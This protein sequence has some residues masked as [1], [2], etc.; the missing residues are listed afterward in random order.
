MDKY[1]IL[2][3]GTPGKGKTTAAQNMDRATTGYLNVECKPLPF[4]GAF[5]HHIKPLTLADAKA[6]LK[7]LV[8]NPAVEAIFFDSFSAYV[9]LVLWEAR[10]TKKGFDV[11]N[12]YS[13]EIGN[14][15]KY[16]K[17]CGKD[18]IVTAHYEV[19]GLEGSQEKRVKVKGNE[20]S[21]LIEKEFTIVL[22]A[23]NRLNE[24]GRP[25]YFFNIFQE[26]TSAKCP[27]DIFGADVYRVPNDYKL[28]MDKL[29]E[30][31]NA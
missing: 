17:T 5:T 19:L 3:V 31:R 8:D 13:E 10:K 12:Y 21:G 29:N 26:G 6:G 4:K 14:I 18:V 9:D 2:I 27:P 7:S 1:Q 15:L 16:I 11:W 25:E 22:Y 30:F 20:W 23:D 24:A 28:V